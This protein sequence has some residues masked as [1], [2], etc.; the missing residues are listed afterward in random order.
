M[1]S[2]KLGL[3]S[4]GRNRILAVCALA[5]PCAIFNAFVPGG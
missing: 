2:F 5:R 4:I 3:D 1:R